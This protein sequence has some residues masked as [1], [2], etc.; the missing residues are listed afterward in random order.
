MPWCTRAT[1]SRPWISAELGIRLHLAEDNLAGALEIVRGAEIMPDTRL[2]HLGIETAYAGLNAGQPEIATSLAD[3][4]SAISPASS[5]VK[6][7]RIDTCFRLL[8]WEDA[9]EILAT[10]PPAEDERPQISMKRLEYACFMG[11]RETAAAA[12]RRME[13]LAPRAGRQVM[14]PVFRYYAEQQDWHAVIDRALPWMDGSLNY[15]QIGYVLFRAAKNGRRHDEVIARIEGIADWQDRDGLLTLRNHLAYDQVRSLADIDA[16]AGDAAIA[17][18]GALM[19]KLAIRRAVL[20]GETAARSRQAV[21]SARI[22]IIYAPPSWRCTASR[23]R[24]IPPTRISTSS[25][26]TI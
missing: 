23:R 11:D 22:A 25:P 24:S 17:A 10:M 4:L 9:G 16:L 12:A 15:K 8:L 14:L 19:H 3:R 1:F 2:F 6:I 18:D 21:F 5:A 7:L 26:M 13:A 20:A